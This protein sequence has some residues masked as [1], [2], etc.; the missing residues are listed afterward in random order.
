MVGGLVKGGEF[1][2]SNKAVTPLL[3]RQVMEEELLLQQ[4]PVQPTMPVDHMGD[5]EL[6]LWTC[7]HTCSMS[8]FTPYP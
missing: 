6:C 5:G 7:G 8:G 4:V 3:E 1:M 2:G